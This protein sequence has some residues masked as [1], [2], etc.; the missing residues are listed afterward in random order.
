M[1]A[2]TVIDEKADGNAT[3]SLWKE[4]DGESNE[5][6]FFFDEVNP[7]KCHYLLMICNLWKVTN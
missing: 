3:Y 1:P 7:G 6:H 2:D 5:Q 4:E